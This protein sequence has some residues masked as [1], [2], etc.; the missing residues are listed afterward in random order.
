MS[1]TGS[2]NIIIG[3]TWLLLNRFV[4]KFYNHIIFLE[5]DIRKW[6]FGLIFKSRTRTK[7]A[8]L[9]VRNKYWTGILPV[10]IARFINFSRLWVD[11]S[12]RVWFSNLQIDKGTQ[13]AGAKSRRRWDRFWSQLH[14]HQSDLFI[15]I[16]REPV[17]L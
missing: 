10:S 17:V 16:S 5:V 1:L 14:W 15:K 12:C 8:S 6:L 2:S 11:Y 7:Q 4:D 13:S 9:V 3:H